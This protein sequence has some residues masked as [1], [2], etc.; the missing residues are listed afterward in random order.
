MTHKPKRTKTRPAQR[1]EYLKA[2]AMLSPMLLGFFIV[3]IG[4]IIGV[5]ALSFTDYSIMWPP[6]FIGLANYKKL[7]SQTLLPK[8]LW[9]SVYYVVLVTV[10]TILLSFLVALLMNRKFRGNA[11]FRAAIFWPVVASMTA[12]SLIWMFLLNSNIGIVNLFL[13]K[14]H[15]TGPKWFG[16]VSLT[17]PVF[18]FIYVWKHLGYYMTIMLGGLSNVPE[19]LYESALLDGAGFWNRTR[20]ITVPLM[21]PTIFYIFIMVVIYGFQVFDQILVISKD[22]GPAYSGLTLSFY[23]YQSAFTNGKMG[24]ASAAGVLLFVII[25]LI[26][27]LQ[28]R[29]QKKWVFY[30]E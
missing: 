17:L 6:K 28:F 14:L 20:Y 24:Y 30:N 10:P 29:V 16:D 19:E 15:I 25:M 8:I 22:G 9:N 11:F 1:R 21:S 23:V 7:F 4:A 26:T 18:A 2:Y 13:N 5:F 27:F 3:T 12:V